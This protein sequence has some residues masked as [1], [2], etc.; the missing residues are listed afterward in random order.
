MVSIQYKQE[1]VWPS[2][3]AEAEAFARRLVD[4]V[5]CP[6]D[7]GI[8]ETVVAFN[9]LGFRTSQSCEGHLDDGLPYPW[10]DFDTDEFP[11]FKQAIEEADREGLS[12]EEKEERGEQLVALAESLTAHGRGQLYTRLEKLLDGYYEQHPPLAEEWQI[13]LRWCSPIFF[14]L[15]PLCGYDAEE[16]S[17]AERAENLARAQAEMQALGKWLRK[18]WSQEKKGLALGEGLLS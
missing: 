16:W 8:I 3:W 5:E 14:R 15:M 12:D 11:T 2:T 17:E 13:I 9:L 18:R 1:L 10:I 4:G 6:I 7:E